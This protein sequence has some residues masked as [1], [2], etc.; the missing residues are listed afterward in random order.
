M[1]EGCSRSELAELNLLFGIN[2]LIK[3]VGFQLLPS[4]AGWGRVRGWAESASW[5]LRFACGF[6]CVW[7]AAS[8][9]E[10]SWFHLYQFPF[11]IRTSQNVSQFSRHFNSCSPIE[12]LVC[13]RLRG[14]VRLSQTVLHCHSAAVP[15]SCPL[16]RALRFIEPP[17]SCCSGGLDLWHLLS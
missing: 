14:V 8:V 4:E 9:V 3:A 13:Q 5:V 12:H 10:Q 15:H 1:S 11:N 2:S 16:L 7:F 6:L 17:P